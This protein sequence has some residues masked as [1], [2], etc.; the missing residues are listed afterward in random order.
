MSRA[1]DLFDRLVAGGEAEVLSFIAQPV[2]E[3]LFLDYK[4]SADGGS[5]NIPGQQGQIEP[6]QGNFRL[7]QLRVVGASSSATTNT[8]K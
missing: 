7:W 5:W 4:R 6:W 1:Q 8:L 2:T 3:E